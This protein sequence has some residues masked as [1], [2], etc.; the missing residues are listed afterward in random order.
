[1]PST[2]ISL[3]AFSLSMI[4]EGYASPFESVDKMQNSSNPLRI[5]AFVFS[6]F[7]VVVNTILYKDTY[8]SWY[9]VKHIS[10]KFKNI[11]ISSGEYNETISKS[12]G[13]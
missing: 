4:S 9:Y 7:I 5:W 2:T 8:K 12:V 1:M 6:M 10:K 13:F 11:T 3:A